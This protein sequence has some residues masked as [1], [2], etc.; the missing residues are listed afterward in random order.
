MSPST[1]QVSR[2]VEAMALLEALLQQRQAVFPAEARPVQ[3]L[4]DSEMWNFDSR[5]ATRCQRGP[6][7]EAELTLCCTPAFFG[8]LLLEPVLYLRPG[9]ELKVIGDPAELK[10]LL[11]ALGGH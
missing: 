6:N 1:V 9:E 10:P 4:L 5:R 2:P 8:R 11:Q 3:I 7:S